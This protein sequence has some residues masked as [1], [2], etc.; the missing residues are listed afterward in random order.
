M[1]TLRILIISP[2][3]SF[4]SAAVSH[5]LLSLEERREMTVSGNSFDIKTG[6]IVHQAHFHLQKL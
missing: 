6:E 1:G 5:F 4:C 3:K 2:T